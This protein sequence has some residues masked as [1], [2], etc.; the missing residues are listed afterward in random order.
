MYVP[1]SQSVSDMFGNNYSFAESDSLRIPAGIKF[2]KQNSNYS[3][4]DLYL[5]NID[6]NASTTATFANSYKV[7]SVNDLKSKYN[8]YKITLENGQ[9]FVRIYPIIQY[10]LS[11]RH[12][13]S[14]SNTITMLL[15]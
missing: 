3:D 4:G 8:E 9:E 2:L 7:T 1:T 12:D 11:V 5:A 10:K 14:K 13:G 15:N 6:V